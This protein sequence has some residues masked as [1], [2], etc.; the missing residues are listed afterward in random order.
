NGLS[1]FQQS[2]AKIHCLPLQNVSTGPISLEQTQKRLSGDHFRRGH[3]M[4]TMQLRW[5]PEFH[6]SN[7]SSD[8]LEDADLVLVFADT[9]HFQA[10]ACFQELRRR[11]PTAHI[12]GCSSAGSV[13]GSTISDA[14]IVATAIRLEQ[15][16][17]RMTSAQV[18]PNTSVRA[19]AEA[20]MAQLMAP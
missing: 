17:A 13:Q 8:N 12:A 19:M 7:C 2:K 15:G 18:D 10:P 9:P 1:Q 4:Q 3:A 14:D 20:L 16:S 11:F 6:W 5:T